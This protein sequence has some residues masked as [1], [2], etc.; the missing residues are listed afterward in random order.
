VA[1][2]GLN[3]MQLAVALLIYRTR[4][5]PYWLAWLGLADFVLRMI[6]QWPIPRHST[7]VDNIVFDYPGPIA[8]G[9]AVLW[10]VALSVVLTFGP[11]GVDATT[12]PI[13]ET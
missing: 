7:T 3:V 4:V 12:H 6:N 9:G 2:L 8:F 5:L 11:A 1:W 13:T 10:V